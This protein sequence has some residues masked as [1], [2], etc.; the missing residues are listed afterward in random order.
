MLSSLWGNYISS[1]SKRETPPGAVLSEFNI[2]ICLVK[3]GQ[4]YRSSIFSVV[5][6]RDIFIAVML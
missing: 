4:E 1:Q 6:A 2:T 3:E 5:V